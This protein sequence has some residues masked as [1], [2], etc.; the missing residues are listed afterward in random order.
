M[1]KVK[2]LLFAVL[3]FI[4]PAAHA[5]MLDFNFDSLTGTH[6]ITGTIT[7]NDAINGVGGHD[8]TGITGFVSG[9]NGGAITG[10]IANPNQPGTYTNYGY[11]ID[12]VLY[13]GAL[14]LDYFGV[15]FTFNG[16]LIGNL[17]GNSPTDYEFHSYDGQFDE[18][19]TFA[20]VP[21]PGTVALLGLGILGIAF[22][23][24]RSKSKHAALPA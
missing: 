17:W 7:Y 21:E 18:H 3:G 19:G 22:A 8:I 2:L 12:N 15:L 5:G 6:D 13:D 20:R 14:A 11:I 16:S 24:K 10:L 1:K 4:I 23:G 9:V